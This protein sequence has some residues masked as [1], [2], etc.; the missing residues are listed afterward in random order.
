[1][2]MK[3]PDALCNGEKIYTLVQSSA[4]RIL[5]T[6][7]PKDLAVSVVYPHA[8]P[9]MDPQDILERWSALALLFR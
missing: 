1:M 7:T 2:H 5:D 4:R 9:R 6:I 3:N 8:W